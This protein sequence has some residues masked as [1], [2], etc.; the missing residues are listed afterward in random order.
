MD[1]SKIQ[2][3]EEKTLIASKVAKNVKEG[4]VIGFGSGTTSYLA[5]LAIAKRIKEE[6]LNIKAV[7]SSN[8]IEKLCATLQI[9]TTN[10]LESKIDWC[11]DGAD[12]IDNQ[13]NM[14]KGYG[15]ALF[16]EKLNFLNSEKIYILVDK[17][18]FSTRIGEKCVVPVEVYPTAIKYVKNELEKLGAKQLTVRKK[19]AGYVI[20]DNGNFIIDAKFDFIEGLLEKRIK[21]ITGVIE[22]GLFFGY[23]VTVIS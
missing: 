12:E 8:E 7:P 6:N 22:S 20:T 23:K 10:L 16:R 9:P 21:Q 14:I 17:S 11:F 5:V 1:I 15:A 13:N 2:N 4:D 19:E 18:K 3:L